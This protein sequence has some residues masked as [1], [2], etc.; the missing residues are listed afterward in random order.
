MRK[1]LYLIIAFL[2]CA[3]CGNGNQQNE[4]NDGKFTIIGGKIYL[5]LNR[6]YD[7][8]IGDDTI[9]SVLNSTFSSKK[10]IGDEKDWYRHLYNRGHILFQN[11]NVQD[12][13]TLQNIILQRQ[14]VRGNYENDVGSNEIISYVKLPGMDDPTSVN[15]G[16]Q[17]AFSEGRFYN[18]EVYRKI[19]AIA[20][21]DDI[22]I[23]EKNSAN[24]NSANNVKIISANKIAQNNTS[25]LLTIDVR[26]SQNDNWYAVDQN[27]GAPFQIRHARQMRMIII[28]G[29]DAKGKRTI[30]RL[31]TGYVQG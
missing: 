10:C 11:N 22:G 21:K 23:F 3:E 4:Y 24:K 15:T 25:I 27:T 28:I 13:G 20:F 30:A 7:D 5:V 16:N 31:L 26:I 6:I 8:R 18:D 17:I 2:F 29:K 19:R 1:I 12:I 14:K 9:L